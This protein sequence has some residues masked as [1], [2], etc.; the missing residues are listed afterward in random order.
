MRQRQSAAHFAAS[1]LS[2]IA[3]GLLLGCAGTVKA[4]DVKPGIF[5]LNVGGDPA[6]TL[7]LAEGIA[8]IASPP[9]DPAELAKAY[10][11]AL[12]PFRVTSKESVTWAIVA[13]GPLLDSP[14]TVQAPVAT[15]ENNIIRVEIAHTGARLGGAGF[16]RNRQWRPLMKLDL[17]P[18]LSPGEYNVEVIWRALESLPN[19]KALEPARRLGPVSFSV[20]K[21]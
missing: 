6:L 20:T 9:A 3:L 10:K 2:I 12:P 13:A 8:I 15:S 11:A 5:E 18:N 14:D 16:R 1:L 21:Q 7:Q 17:D 4:L 19:G